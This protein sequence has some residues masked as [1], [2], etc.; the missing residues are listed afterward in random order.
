MFFSSHDIKVDI[1][2]KFKYLAVIQHCKL[3]VTSFGAENKKKVNQ[4]AHKKNMTC[5][6]CHPT[7]QLIATGDVDGKIFLWRNILGK[8]FAMTVN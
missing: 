2:N 1:S 8:G 5:V 4:N 6:K 7:E 3:Y